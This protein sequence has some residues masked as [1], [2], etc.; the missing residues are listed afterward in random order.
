MSRQDQYNVTA[1]VTFNGRT[2]NLGTFDQMG[3]GEVDSSEKKFYPGGLQPQISLGG[4]KVVNNVTV[5]RLYKL[6]RDHP[7]KGWLIAAVGKGTVVITKTSLD[8]DGN[9]FGSPLVYNGTLKQITFPE[10][11]SESDDA[12]MVELEITSA[13]VAG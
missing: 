6:E 11:D 5:S 9:V 1:S 7:L 12:A 4:K 3:G 10:P 8:V 2:E 13:S